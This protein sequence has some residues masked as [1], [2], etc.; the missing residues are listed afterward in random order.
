MSIAPD[1]TRVTLEELLASDDRGRFEIVEGQ[2][3]EI[4]VSVR[5]STVG[6][7]LLILMGAFCLDQK[8]GEAFGADMYY[9]CYPEDD[10]KSR[11]PDVSFVSLARLPPDWSDL[12]Y[13][14]IPPDLAVEVVSENDTS[15]EIDHKIREYLRVGVRMVWEVNPVERIVLV[16]RPG[17]SILS[18]EE[19]DTL[20]GDDVVPGFAC[21]VGDFLV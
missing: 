21:R 7:R 6:S 12:S 19:N 1:E 20:S 4:N 5:S 14:P 2:L 13:M 15:Y 8:L 10:S 11:K 3:E 16:Y 9:R 17:K 18:L